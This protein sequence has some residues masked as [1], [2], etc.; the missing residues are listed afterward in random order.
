MA[1]Q[2]GSECLAGHASLATAVSS[3]L[4][5]QHLGVGTIRDGEKMGWHLSTASATVNLHDSVG[6]DRESLVGIDHNAEKTRVG[7]RD[8]EVDMKKKELV[9]VQK[10]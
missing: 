6:V 4:T 9:A 10:D 7:L 2:D 5:G 8:E 1:Q 3:Q